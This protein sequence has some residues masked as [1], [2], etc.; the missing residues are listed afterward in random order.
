MKISD[1]LP[2]TMIPIVKIQPA[3]QVYFRVISMDVY[4]KALDETERE[5]NMTAFSNAKSRYKQL[6]Q[7][8]LEATTERAPIY[9]RNT[10]KR[11]K[12]YG[13]SLQAKEL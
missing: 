10:R 5:Q 11:N 7:K 3:R 8:L 2:G 13:K 9:K 1:N 12:R 4:S 6:Y